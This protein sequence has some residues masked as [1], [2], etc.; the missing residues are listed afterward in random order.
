LDEAIEIQK[1]FVNHE[2]KIFQAIQHEPTLKLETEYLG[3]SVLF[4]S[5]EP[6][7]NENYFSI[8][9]ACK[10]QQQKQIKYSK[11]FALTFLRVTSD[12]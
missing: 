5:A 2:L 12:P 8:L 3:E 1:I 9:C 7:L 11:T 10:D 4:F 6:F